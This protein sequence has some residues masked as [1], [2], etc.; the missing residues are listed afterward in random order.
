MTGRLS[1]MNYT[2]MLAWNPVILKHMM[3]S[4]KSPGWKNHFSGTHRIETLSRTAQFSRYRWKMSPFITRP[5]AQPDNRC[6]SL[7]HGRTGTGARNTGLTYYTPRDR[8]EER[9]VGKEGRS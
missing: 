6:F 2:K 9:R 4:E 1:T 5:V 3:T 7:I 8:S